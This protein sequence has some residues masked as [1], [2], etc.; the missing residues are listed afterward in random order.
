MLQNTSR[1]SAL[2]EGAASTFRARL[3]GTL[4]RPNDAG[5]DEARKV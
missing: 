2:D 5:Y 4:I 3:R 1:S